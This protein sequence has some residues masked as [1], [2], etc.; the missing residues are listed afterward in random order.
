MHHHITR[1][2]YGRTRGW[3]VR[4]RRQPNPCSKLFS[5]RI[6]G[7]S[8][9][10]LEAALA[11]RDE[12]LEDRPLRKYRYQE[13]VHKRIKTG[14]VGLY[15]INKDRRPGTQGQIAVSVADRTGRHIGT[16][17][18]ISKWG[19]RRALWK[20]CVFLAQQRTESDRAIQAMAQEFFNTSYPQIQEHLDAGAPEALWRSQKD[21]KET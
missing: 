14:V 3:W 13:S 1:F 18:S 5:D 20:A 10:A 17:Y 8:E 9:K 21:K 2:D 19:V 6:F 16:Q 4:I 12:K 15:L 7:S 11:W